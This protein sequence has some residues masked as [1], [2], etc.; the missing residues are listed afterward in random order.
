MRT[1]LAAPH[2]AAVRRTD[3]DVI[4]TRA[5]CMRPYVEEQFYPDLRQL[6]D[7]FKKTLQSHRMDILA[8]NAAA[9]QQAAGNIETEDLDI[10]VLD[11]K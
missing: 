2:K 1:S 8:A 5:G 6:H 4:V 7:A 3:A 11:N 10:T 9:Q